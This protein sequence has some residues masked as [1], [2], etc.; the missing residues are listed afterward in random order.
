MHPIHAAIIK[1][2]DRIKA[3]VHL[4]ASEEDLL[5]DARDVLMN[6]HELVSCMI[7]WIGQNLGLSESEAIHP[8]RGFL[9]LTLSDILAHLVWEEMDKVEDDL[10]CYHTRLL[11]LNEEEY[12]VPPQ[13]NVFPVGERFGTEIAR[14]EF[15][16]GR[17]DAEQAQA[18]DAMDLDQRGDITR[19]IKD[20][21]AEEKEV[22]FSDQLYNEQLAVANQWNAHL[23]KIINTVQPDDYIPGI[24]AVIKGMKEVRKSMYTHP[25]FRRAIKDTGLTASIEEISSPL[26]HNR[27][28]NSQALQLELK[29]RIADQLSDVL[30]RWTP[31]F[32]KTSWPIASTAYLAQK[33]G[34]KKLTEPK[35]FLELFDTKANLMPGAQNVSYCFFLAN[36]HTFRYNYN[37]WL[38][39]ALE[40]IGYNLT[41]FNN[42]Q[43]LAD[44]YSRVISLMI[45]WCTK[46]IRTR[47]GLS[48]EYVINLKRFE[49]PLWRTIIKHTVKL[50]LLKRMASK[51]AKQLKNC[52]GCRD[53]PPSLRCTQYLYFPHIMTGLQ[54]DEK[55]AKLTTLRDELIG[56]GITMVPSDEQIQPRQTKTRK[57]K[58]RRTYNTDMY[59]PDAVGKTNPLTL[60]CVQVNEDIVRRCGHQLCLIVDEEDPKT[61]T[62]QIVNWGMNV[63]DFVWFNPFNNETLAVL[64]DAVVE[65]TGVSALK[66][67]AQ[68]ESYS[69]GTMIPLGSRTASGGRPGDTYTSYAGL[70]ATS[71][72]GLDILF[73]QAAI[74][75]IMRAAA[76]HAHSKIVDKL[77]DWCNECDHMGMTGA[78]IYNCTGYMA[79]IHRDQDTTRGLC[80][81]VLLSAD[82]SRHEF[83]FC[84]IEYKYFVATTTN[85]LWSFHSSDLHGTM[86]PSKQTIESLNSH[87]LD[88]N[89]A[90]PVSASQSSAS[91]SSGTTSAAT[92]SGRPGHS[93]RGSRSPPIVAGAEY[94]GEIRD[95]QRRMPEGGDNMNYGADYGNANHKQFLMFYCTSTNEYRPG[96]LAAECW[97]TVCKQSHQR[98]ISL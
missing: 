63:V 36:F 47:D 69:G 22:L 29:Y 60:Q 76:V 28:R 52:L 64:Q 56:C 42:E 31:T 43:R 67:G 44:F 84:N 71:E 68:F 4:H 95:A 13:R 83:G 75:D 30:D 35:E 46:K 24:L 6:D 88:P 82:S 96:P 18:D 17:D 74:A 8:D 90:E 33:D 59:H 57:T 27:T 9:L 66:R 77:E 94:R 54:D 11:E 19:Q 3:K 37:R 32:I 16:S 45:E 51:Y 81:Q 21:Q 65:S 25:A 93:G 89:R 85:C 73:N 78:N 58:S 62:S 55:E 10:S 20:W 49:R 5:D 40:E 48:S 98:N 38:G 2:R 12:D 61:P 97:N 1:E 53:L 7:G 87:A 79:P 34:K 86:L 91:T 80:T 23:R 14:E 72:K 26:F 15:E 92:G 50:R 39:S 41:N 70:D